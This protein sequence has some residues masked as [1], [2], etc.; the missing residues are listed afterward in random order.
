MAQ[1]LSFKVSLEGGC[2]LPLNVVVFCML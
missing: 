2:E 1:T